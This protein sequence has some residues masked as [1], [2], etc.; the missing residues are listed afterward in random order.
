MFKGERRCGV[1]CNYMLHPYASVKDGW[2]LGRGS[3]RPNAQKRGPPFFLGI[4]P[5]HSM[6]HVEKARR[7]STASDAEWAKV[8]LR[9]RAMNDLR[10]H[11]ARRAQ[12]A[13]R[14]L[15]NEATAIYDLYGRGHA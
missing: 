8:I 2:L 6:I 15:K 13:C 9:F 12:H 5:V 11:D 4:D 10:D 7:R 3:P 14:L 1:H